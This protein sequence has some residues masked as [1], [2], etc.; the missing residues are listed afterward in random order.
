MK[1]TPLSTT[2]APA[3]RFGSSHGY[4]FVGDSV[5]L[6]ATFTITHRGAHDRAWALQLWA[7]PSVPARSDDLV[8]HLVAE[9]PLP[10]IAEIAGETEAFVVTA[11]AQPPAGDRDHSMVLVLVARRAGSGD[12]DEVHDVASFPARERFHL[13]RLAGPV[14]YRVD[15]D[16]VRLEIAAI[17]NPRDAAN[18]SG[19]I[20]VE[21]WALAAP[22]SGGNFRGAPLAGAVL[23]TLAG[24]GRWTQ[25]SLELPYAAPAGAESQ[26]VV[27]VREWT[28]AGYT[29]R[30]FAN[31]GALEPRTPAEPAAP[32]PV[33]TPTLLP[34]ATPPV[35][36]TT[37]PAPAPATGSGKISLNSATIEQLLTIKGLPRA[38]AERIVR[39]RPF[40]TVNDILQ[41]KGMGEKLL[42]RI[43]GQL[44]L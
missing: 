24:Q 22:Y 35:V 12:F 20:S 29:T 18:L 42:T 26:V 32:A 7:C 23:G 38:V 15:G 25:L 19:T 14:G 36:A 39:D 16:R 2:T 44:T 4:R 31:L 8:G 10:P 9:A 43:R 11:P 34:P 27:M 40:G 33:P 28:G 37:K 21:L 17:E 30:D 41:V 6:N 13:P 3:V 1:T 5:E